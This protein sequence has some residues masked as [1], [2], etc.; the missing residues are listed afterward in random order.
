[1]TVIKSRISSERANEIKFHADKLSKYKNNY[2]FKCLY[3]F[4]ENTIVL[5][6]SGDTAKMLNLVIAS[7]SLIIEFPEAHKP[8]LKI[9]TLFTLLKIRNEKELKLLFGYTD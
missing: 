1:M 4:L 8:I 2:W 9:S 7:C 3:K 5:I 6:K